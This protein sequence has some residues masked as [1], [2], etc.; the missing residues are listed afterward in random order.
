MRRPNARQRILDVA[1]DLFTKR[2]YGMVGINEIIRESGTAKASFYQHFPSK[3]DLC[4]TWLIRV[5]ERSDAEHEVILRAPGSAV[6][7]VIGYFQV[8][9]EW[10]KAKDFRGCPFTNTVACLE[11][12]SPAIAEVVEVY[13]RSIRDFFIALAREIAADDGAARR[14]GATLFLLHSGAMMEAQNLRS[15]WPIDAAIESIG[16]L[17]ESGASPK[18]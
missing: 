17:L 16:K 10:M 3:E 9:K 14:L 2:G 8:L 6:E 7:K 13:K 15:V 1:A 5:H 11:R 18:I 12:N 4:L